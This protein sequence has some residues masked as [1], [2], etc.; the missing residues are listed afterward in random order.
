MSAIQWL[1]AIACGL[2]MF[3][4]GYDMQV[5]ALAVPTVARQWAVPPEQFSLALAAVS[6]GLAV[7]GAFIAPLGDRFGRR[8]LVVTAL[9]IAGAAT[10][11][12]S[13][14]SGAVE[15]VIWRFVTGLAWARG[16]RTAMPGPVN[17]PRCAAGRPCW[18]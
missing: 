10:L 13:T 8:T 5:M 16:S 12:T 17:T 18:C 3:V 14:A 15:F 7:G 6:I 1:V 9:L 2:T 4:D 11:A